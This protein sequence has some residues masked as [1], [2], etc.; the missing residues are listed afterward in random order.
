M[1][2]EVIDRIAS[3]TLTGRMVYPFV[4]QFAVQWREQERLYPG[5]VVIGPTL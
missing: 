3:R 5:A 1:Y 4:D 2:I